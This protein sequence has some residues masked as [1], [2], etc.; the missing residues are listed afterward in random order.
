[1]LN[2]EIAVNKLPLWRFFKNVEKQIKNIKFK[3]LK[4]Q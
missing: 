1:M 4:F 3:I 2:L